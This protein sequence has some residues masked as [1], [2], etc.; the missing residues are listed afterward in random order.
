MKLS[1]IIIGGLG[2]LTIIECTYAYSETGATVR[3]IEQ[4]LQERQGRPS[5]RRLPR[6]VRRQTTEVED[7]DKIENPAV[8]DL[9]VFI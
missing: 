1:T 8:D 7:P 5:F 2:A 6:T 4:R 9:F 3:E